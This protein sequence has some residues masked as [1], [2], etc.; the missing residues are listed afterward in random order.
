V[1]QAIQ[2]DRVVLLGTGGTIAGRAEHAADNVGYVAGQVGV[3]ELVAAVPALGG[4]P[5]EV[6]QVAQIDSKD[7][8]LVVWQ[9]LARRIQAHLDRPEVSA[10]IVTHGNDTIE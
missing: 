7:M 10:V 9:L 6:E 2:A 5:L 3:G 8:G 4:F 1:T